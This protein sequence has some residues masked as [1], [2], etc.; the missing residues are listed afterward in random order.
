MVTP[1]VTEM[2]AI[3]WKYRTITSQNTCLEF[4]VQWFHLCPSSPSKSSQIKRWI[5]NQNWSSSKYEPQINC[6]RMRKFIS[7][8]FLVAVCRECLN[9][10]PNG[11]N[12]CCCKGI[13]RVLTDFRG[14]SNNLLPFIS[15]YY[16]KKSSVHKVEWLAKR[17]ALPIK[18][19]CEA[20][21]YDC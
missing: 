21:A 18:L 9:I 1:I 16:D 11:R 6:S 3:I 13:V 15:Q 12:K 20:N 4:S 7:K 19:Y 14:K 10:S 2:F 5:R 17:M 8:L